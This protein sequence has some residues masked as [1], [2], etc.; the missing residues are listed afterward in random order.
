MPPWRVTPSHQHGPVSAPHENSDPHA[1][2]TFCATS[3]LPAARRNYQRTAAAT[4]TV[5]E[6]GISVKLPP[7]GR[8]CS[9]AFEAWYDKSVGFGR[10]ARRV[11]TLTRDGA[12]AIRTTFPRRSQLAAPHFSN[13]S[14][15][16]GS[17]LDRNWRRAR[18]NGPT[19][20]L[21]SAGR[22]VMRHPRRTRPSLQ[23]CAR[24][25]VQDRTHPMPWT[26]LPGTFS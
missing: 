24:A 13:A 15:K 23:D 22:R 16:S 5:S 18:R 12:T 3:T 10:S 25:C 2:Q 11:A 7:R 4:K 26:W 9:R 1:S 14:H 19:Q 8:A 20:L 21:A 6:P 17:C